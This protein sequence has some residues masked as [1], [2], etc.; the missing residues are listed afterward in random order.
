M[1]KLYKLTPLQVSKSNKLG[2][3]AD[4]GGLYCLTSAPMAQ[5]LC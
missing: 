3:I 4:G 1:A 5:V 2:W